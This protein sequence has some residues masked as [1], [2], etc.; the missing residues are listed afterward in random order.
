MTPPPSNPTPPE[1]HYVSP[2]TKRRALKD[3]SFAAAYMGVVLFLTLSFF[4]GMISL[5]GCNDNEKN[6][7][8]NM[9]NTPQ[10]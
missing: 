10:T 6:M 8:Q 7:E 1:L 2:S 3:S 4:I 5:K 9:G